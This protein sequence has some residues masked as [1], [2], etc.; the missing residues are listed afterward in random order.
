MITGIL[1]AHPSEASFSDVVHDLQAIADDPIYD[2]KFEGAPLPQVHALNCLKDVFT[3]A[4]FG[5][6]TEV[7]MAD[8]IEIACSCL[9]SHVYDIC[10]LSESTFMLTYA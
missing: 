6:G 8:T 10:Y 5:S 7:H 2:P 4:Q 1:A 9:E 3:D